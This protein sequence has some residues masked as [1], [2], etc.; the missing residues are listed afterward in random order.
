M[1]EIQVQLIS[2]DPDVFEIDSDLEN[3]SL[4]TST[5]K[6][7]L[8]SLVKSQLVDPDEENLPQSFAF[9]VNGQLFNSA[10]IAQHILLHQIQTES[11]VQIHFFVD[12]SAP[13]PDME[14]PHDDWVSSLHIGTSSHL[15]SS[16][17]SGT[18]TLWSRDD[19]NYGSDAE[20]EIKQSG[21]DNALTRENK[22]LS[23]S[24]HSSAVKR[25]RWIDCLDSNG[26]QGFITCSMDQTGIIW[27]VDGRKHKKADKSSI[28]AK[29]M[30]KLKGHTESID[31]VDVRN[32]KIVTGGYDHMIK[33]WDGS[34]EEEVEEEEMPEKKGPGQKGKP[35]TEKCLKLNE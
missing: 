29:P 5:T 27:R 34:F 12:V 20:A 3:L 32:A 33:V 31:A 28:R 4:P 1:A 25:V 9:L 13:E 2:A 15:I 8:N 26:K 10:T 14:Y 6:D 23:F 11:Q 30:F 21:D 19:D 35:R 18:V 22:D 16:T 7:Q 17:Y 24:A